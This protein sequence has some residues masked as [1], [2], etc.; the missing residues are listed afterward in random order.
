M[1]LRKTG[2]GMFCLLFAVAGW[3]QLQP[4]G[5]IVGVV[6]DPKGGV[7][8]NVA[9]AITNVATGISRKSATNSS[10]D[11]LVPD[12]LPGT[13]RVE[14]E[15]QGFKKLIR[16]AVVQT[17]RSTTVDMTMELGSTTQTV[18]VTAAVPLLQ[19]TTSSLTTTVDN[20]YIQDLPLAGRNPLM[21]AKLSPGVVQ[22]Y[23]QI[24]A[25]LDISSMNY[26]S[27]FSSNGAKYSSNDF[28]IDGIPDNL[29]DRA[30]YMPPT[31]QTEDV[32]VLTNAFDAQYGHGNGASIVVTTKSGTNQFHGSVYDYLQN[33]ALNASSFFAN[34]AGFKKPVSQYNQF[35][36]TFGGPI[37]HN[38][39]FFFFNYEGIRYKNPGVG[40]ATVP[41]ALQRQ[42]NFSKTY[43]QYGNLVQIYNPFTTR[44]DPN[45]PGQYIRDPFPG[46]IIPQTMINPASAG[47]LALVPM[48]NRQGLP[49]TNAQNYA[50][51]STV[52]YPTNDYSIRVD[53][54]INQNNRLFVRLSRQHTDWIYSTYNLMPGLSLFSESNVGGLGFTSVLTP[55][56][57]LDLTLG[58]QFFRNDG[59]VPT[60][61]LAPL[62][63]S[64]S[65]A[66]SVPVQYIPSVNIAD[67]G[68]FG[69][70]V[71]G[72]HDHDP[73]WSFNANMRHMQ[74]IQSMK[75]GFQTQIKQSNSGIYSHTGFYSFGRGFTQGP[76][77][78]DVGTNIGY[79]VA[80]Y[81]LG[82][83]DNSS[84]VQ[85]PT[86]SATT[87]PYYGA[88]FQ[89]DIRATPKL[90]LNLGLRWDA[91]QPATERYNRQNI[92][93]AFNTPNPI[94]AQA[95]ANYTANPLPGNILPPNQFQVNGGLLFATPSNRRWG[96]TYW[97]EWSPRVGFAYRLDNK[98]VLRGGVGYFRG[99]FWTTFNGGGT[100]FSTN[101]YAVGS[102]NGIT[103]DNLLN[104]PFPN[105][106]NQ[107]SGSSL[108]LETQLGGGFGFKDP[109]GQ[110]GENARWSIGLQ[111]QI[112][113][114]TVVEA[115]YVGETSYYLPVGSPGNLAGNYYPGS[116]GAAEQDRILTYLPAKYLALGSQLSNLVPNPFYGL[117]SSGALS[118]PQISEGQLLSNYP[119]F[120]L[121]DMSRQT[122]GMSYYHSLQIS[123]T[124][125]YSQGLSLMGAY[126]FSKNMD[127]SRFINVSNPGPSKMI[128]VYD[129]PQRFTLG[130][131][132]ALPFGPGQNLGW[133]SGVGGKLVG[134]WQLGVNG[135]FQSGF[136]IALNAP[137]IL[138]GVNPTLSPSNRN[139]LDWFN[140][141]ALT[142]LPTFTLRNAPWGVSSLRSD[143]IDNWDTSLT[144]KIQLKER[145]GLQFRWEMFNAL[146]Q[147]QFGNPDVNPL[148]S[149]YGQIFSQANNPRVMQM[150]LTVLF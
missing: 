144:K 55:T 139:R 81:L 112:T 138:T 116:G 22:T 110:P 35:G 76:N 148:S 149:T 59:H 104:N 142:V 57:I 34:L 41:T 91:W 123:V 5:S 125:R 105:G 66:N 74:G 50:Y 121:L 100:G 118:G 3:A 29:Y 93:F 75:W 128:A 124:K 72:Y 107:V 49:F 94:A 99:L 58:A 117:I 97:N 48:P 131:V 16:E 52:T 147:V 98:T 146:N 130:A 60:T 108:G 80:T 69:Y 43:D 136:P 141:A 24:P 122:D 135:V 28:M 78:F 23:P 17:G 45:N 33:S 102:L 8:P 92:G 95:I 37:W 65:F 64:S 86:N 46:N 2:L 73:A 77:P 1:R 9:I 87:G 132:Y 79:G 140:K 83:M 19:T 14:A 114:S 129:A 15:I 31:D 27:Y 137:I 26:V 25:G 106:F 39:T 89:D 90:T 68:G 85:S 111:R 88:Y 120:T 10:G 36:G 54:Q 70:P 71:Y 18:Q 103:P 4:T 13:Y 20:R 44:P 32:T 6:K 133:K 96:K 63:F 38:H 47:L 12:I 42:G 127:R 11:F 109:N 145:L 119:E 115:Y 21:L 143:A 113:P 67:F 84:Y 53:H 51:P 101:T 62:G 61:K 150:S 7:V 82:T 30:E 56:T 126:T 40:L 134:G